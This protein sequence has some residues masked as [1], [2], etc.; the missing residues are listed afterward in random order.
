MKSV[1]LAGGKGTRLGPYTAVLPK[2]LMPIG[3]LP[4]L[5]IV[6]NQLSRTKFKEV[7]ITVGHLS[8]LIR[9]YFDNVS[10]PGISVKY[11]LEDKPLGTAGPLKLISGLDDT[12]LVMNGDVLADIDFGKFYS[13]HKKNNAV[14]TAGIYKRSVHIDFGV[15]SLE[16][17][18][19][20][21]GYQEKPTFEYVVSMG[22]YLFEPEVLGYIKYN[23]YLDLPDLIKLLIKNNKTVVGYLHDG[24]WLDIGRPEDYNKAVLD[25]KSMRFLAPSINKKKR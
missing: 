15:L 13:F 14:A 6:L 23:K 2:P 8:S 25:F 12:F 16:Q 5:E 11:S 24:Y 21:I 3:D 1:I 19:K 7:I 17:N 10:I 22:V 9:T 4:I 18:K 20:I